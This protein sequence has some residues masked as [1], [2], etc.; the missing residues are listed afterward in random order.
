MHW[1]LEAGMIPTFEQLI[2]RLRRDVMRQVLMVLLLPVLLFQQPELITTPPVVEKHEVDYSREIAERMG[3]IAEAR[4]FDGV[5][6]DVLTEDEAI[7]VEY[8][9]KWAEAIGQSLYYATVTGEDP[10]IVLLVSDPAAERKYIYR[11]LVVAAR[12]GITVRLE[13]TK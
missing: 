8:P 4:L 13:E 6:V 11:C 2:E 7:E 9:R 12:C 10:V 1:E 3:G 5:R